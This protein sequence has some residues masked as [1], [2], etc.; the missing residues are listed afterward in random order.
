MQVVRM[1]DLALERLQTVPD[2][3]ACPPDTVGVVL[4]EKPDRDGIVQ[5]IQ[6][7]QAVQRRPVIDDRAR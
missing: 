1:V 7:G 2:D 4:L 5:Y 3:L 6:A